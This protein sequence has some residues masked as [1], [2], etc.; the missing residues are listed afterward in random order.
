M[1]LIISLGK[2][3]D[4]YEYYYGLKIKSHKNNAHGNIDVTIGEQTISVPSHVWNNPRI[5]NDDDW[6]FGRGEQLAGQQK[7][8]D[9]FRKRIDKYETIEELTEILNEE[10]MRL[11]LATRKLNEITEL[12]NKELKDGS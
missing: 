5:I 4:F 9:A 11:R 3:D 8:I 12:P 2:V 1:K 6:N 10:T 7:R